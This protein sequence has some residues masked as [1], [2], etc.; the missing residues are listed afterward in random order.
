MLKT[1]GEIF[2]RHDVDLLLIQLIHIFI[3]YHRVLAAQRVTCLALRQ[4]VYRSPQTFQSEV[5]RN[6]SD[7]HDVVICLQH[8]TNCRIKTN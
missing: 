3:S 6:R 5:T 1:V 7:S 2:L 4:Y 8:Q